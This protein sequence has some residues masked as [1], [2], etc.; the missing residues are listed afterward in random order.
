VLL[1]EQ[2]MRLAFVD[3]FL[4]VERVGEVLRG[5]DDVV[6]ERILLRTWVRRQACPPPVVL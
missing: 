2:I 3:R 6:S 4:G 5:N 1:D